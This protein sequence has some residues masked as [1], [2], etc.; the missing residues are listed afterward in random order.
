MQIDQYGNKVNTY[1][2]EEIP[3]F[4]A[5]SSGSTGSAYNPNDHFTL[6]ISPGVITIVSS[7]VTMTKSFIISGYVDNDR[8]IQSPSNSGGSIFLVS[9]RLIIDDDSLIQA[10]G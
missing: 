5:I 4:L 1:N 2:G 7:S 10:G 6:P 3:S 8:D 9:K